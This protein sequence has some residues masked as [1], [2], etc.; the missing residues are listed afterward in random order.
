[1]LLPLLRGAKPPRTC[2]RGGAAWKRASVSVL[3]GSERETDSKP[4][5]TTGKGVECLKKAKRLR[6]KNFD[7]A[8]FFFCCPLSLLRP[9][10]P[11]APL[12]SSPL[13][14]LVFDTRADP[15][16]ITVR[17]VSC[18]LFARGVLSSSSL[19]LLLLRL[20]RLLPL[21]AQ[22]PLPFFSSAD[23]S[24]PPE[25][26]VVVAEVAKAEEASLPS[27]RSSRATSMDEGW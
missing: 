10:P 3:V 1:M 27:S 7:F 26:E 25:A 14:T 19:R 22:S 5:E 8:F 13:R 6:S 12:S 11:L 21:F 23:L 18:F 9:R 15:L 4:I 16:K 17:C 20:L 24:P 2:S